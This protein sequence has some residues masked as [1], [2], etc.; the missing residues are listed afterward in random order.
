[1]ALGLLPA[2]IVSLVLG[3]GLIALG[4]SLPALTDAVTPF[5]DGW[6]GVWAVLLRVTLGAAI[7]GA[8]LALV[9]VTFTA[10]TLMVGEPFYDRIWRATEERLT[11]AVPAEGTGFWRGVADALSL[12]ARGAGVGVVC[13]LIG[14]VPLVGGVAAAVVGVAWTGWLLADELTSRALT[15][16]GIDRRGRRRLLRS[17]RPRTLGFGIATQLFFLVPLG[18]V[19]TMPAAVVGAT[20]LA[21]RLAEKRSTLINK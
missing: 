5:A 8:A 14:L 20:A 16:R 9:A 19:V 18:A 11:G 7:F 4:A 12:V 2:A 6:P 17:A 10:L 21:V 1:M 13:F 3:A 15:A